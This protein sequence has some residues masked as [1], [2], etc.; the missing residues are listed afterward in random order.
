MTVVLVTGG[1]SGIGAAVAR[2][3][4]QAGANVVV[5]DVNE[6]GGTAVAAE[7]GGRFV[8]VDVAQ[9]ADN[10]AAVRVALDE[11][12][13]LDV[14]HLNAGIGGAGGAGTDFDIDRYRRTMAVNLDGVMF[15]LHAVLPTLASTGGG[16]IVVTS[17]LAGVAPAPFDPIYGATK[18]AVIGLVRSLAP[19]WARSGITIN[20]VC[21]G[22]VD[23]AIL[24]DAGKDMLRQN[25]LA[26]ADPAEV[27][28]AVDFVATSGETGT[29]WTIQ[30]GQS[31]A[32]V[33]FAPVQLVRTESSG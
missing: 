6:E 17:S 1:A 23:T 4:G 30:A 22:F 9:V 5:A 21:P 18:H 16:A 14:V 8:P 29:A 28:A 31:P 32:R 2:R 25:G 10:E 3:F 19:V 20:A 11:F 15:G 7:I 12:G 13:G 26:L 27:A 33:E 24:T